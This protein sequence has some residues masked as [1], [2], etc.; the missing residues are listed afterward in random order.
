M[1]FQ[2]EM[3]EYC[4]PMELLLYLVRREELPLSDL[5]LAKLTDQ[6]LTY[7][8]VLT[9]LS[10]DDVADFLGDRQR[11]DRDEGESDFAAIARCG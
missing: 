1:A 2:V 5:S 11:L 6:Y 7:L 3:N 4:G 10:I 9:E 8:E